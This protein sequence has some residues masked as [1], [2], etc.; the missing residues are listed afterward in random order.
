MAQR[1]TDEDLNQIN[2]FLSRVEGGAVPNAEAL[3]GFFTALACCDDQIM[4]SEFMPALQAGENE[5]G[6]LVFDSMEEAQRFMTLVMR[7]WNSV[8]GQLNSNDIYLPIM[9][10]DDEG[11]ARGNDWANGF[12]EGAYLRWN[13]WADVFEDEEKAGFLA[14]ILVLGYENHPD[15]DMRP[16]KEPVDQKSRTDLI[17]GVAAGVMRLRAMFLA[18]RSDFLP[19]SDTFVRAEPKTGRNEPCPCGSGKKFKKCCGGRPTFH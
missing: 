5:D 2:G 6:D 16:D 1:M 8:N 13:I 3:D 17:V 11:V 19:G 9:M 12:L 7:H 15:A 4:P 14:P 18:H 10:A